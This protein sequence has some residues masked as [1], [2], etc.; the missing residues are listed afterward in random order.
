MTDNHEYRL[1]WVDRLQKLAE[2]FPYGPWGL[3]LLLAFIVLV[4]FYALRWSY[5]PAELLQ[6][7]VP[8]TWTAVFTPMLLAIGY[9]TDRIAAQSLD[10]FRP[11][12]E[13]EDA[14][15]AQSSYGLSTTP[16]QLVIFGHLIAALFFLG[17]LWIDP[18]WFDLIGGDPL[19]DATI[20]IVRWLNVSMIAIG[21]FGHI[22]KLSIVA[23]LHQK[24]TN[25]GLI[26]WEP[27][28]AFSRLAFWIAATLIFVPTALFIIFLA[29]SENFF[30]FAGVIVAYAVAA[31]AFFLPLRGLNN[32]LVKEKMYLLSQVRRRIRGTSEKLHTMVDRSELSNMEALYGVLAALILE[33]EYLEKLRTWPWPKGMVLRL[34]GLIAIPVL[35][36]V[37]QSLIDQLI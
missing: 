29:F 33:E 25:L 18:T 19:S 24:A 30:A 31:L 27:I 7:S 1:S 9:M 6:L 22:R 35:I 5:H 32:L 4:W 15:F 21:L 8:W 23:A 13:I 2:R 20:N 17:M 26:D 34:L 12:L 16:P 28:F 37:V 3:Y 11:G 36:F 10:R 14:E